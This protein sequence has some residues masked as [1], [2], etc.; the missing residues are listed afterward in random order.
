[1]EIALS[2]LLLVGGTLLLYFG[3]EGLIAGS[4]SLAFKVGITPL[5][6]GLTIIAFGTSSPELVVNIQAAFEGK[7]G[8]AYGNVIGSNIANIA[9]I[10]GLASLI[11]PIKVNVKLVKTDLFILIGASALLIILILDGKLSRLDGIVLFSGIILYNVATI[12]FARRENK[13]ILG[14]ATPKKQRKTWMDVLFIGGGLAILIVG[15]DLFLRGAIHIAKT[16]NV[17]DGIIGI[18]LVALGTSLP[19]LATSVVASVRNEADISVG[20]AIGSNIFNI[21]MV[22]GVAAVIAPI[23]VSAENTGVNIYDLASMT[24]IALFIYPLARIGMNFSRVKGLILLAFYIIYMLYQYE[25]MY[26][27]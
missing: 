7:P 8:I 22:L 1:M 17:P 4:A 15:S 13:K 26:G 18:T 12:Y 11:R 2:L 10:I 19:E 25:K 3:A 9:L 23:N 24:L 16:F 6:I 5:V 20:N 27:I 21:L 14:D